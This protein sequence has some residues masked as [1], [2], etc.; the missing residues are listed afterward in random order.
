MMFADDMV[1]IA[2]VINEELKQKNVYKQ[3]SKIIKVQPV[4]R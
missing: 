2:V 3:I 1:I 4:K